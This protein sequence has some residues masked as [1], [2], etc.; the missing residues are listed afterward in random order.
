MTK[1]DFVAELAL[2]LGLS[3]N[4]ANET[5]EV[6]LESI[7]NAVKDTERLHVCGCLFKK[8]TRKARNGRN[9]KTGESMVI[10]ERT[11]IVFRKRI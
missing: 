2:K 4:K 6:V 11:D 7:E 3:K 9:P 10:P 8:V 5:L 1:A